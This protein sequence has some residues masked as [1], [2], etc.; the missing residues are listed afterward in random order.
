MRRTTGRLDEDLLIA[1]RRHLDEGVRRLLPV[2]AHLVIPGQPCEAFAYI[3]EGLIQSTLLRASGEHVIVERIG[4]GSICGEGP[5][6]HGAP[7]AVE[8]VA[9]EPTRIVLFDRSQTGRLFQQD[10]EFGL[11]IARIV[12]IKYLRLLER[13]GALADNRP[14]ERLAELLT[15]LARL[16]GEPHPRGVLIRTKVTHEDMA[17]MTGL[18]RVTVTRTIAGMRRSSRLEM[19]GGEYLLCGALGPP[20]GHSLDGRPAATITVPSV[21]ARRSFDMA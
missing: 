18:S 10:P 8:M 16:W 4:P 7:P 12:S 20:G 21:A 17:A 5:L 13:F 2:G 19:V 6:M 11:A 1:V 9:I 14:A 3:E 15:R